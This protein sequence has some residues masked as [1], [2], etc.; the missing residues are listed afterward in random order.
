AYP[1]VGM[2]GP[3]Y[4][5]Y[6]GTIIKLDT[7]PKNF[8]ATF[9]VD[10]DDDPTAEFAMHFGGSMAAGVPLTVCIDDTY[11]ADPDYTAPPPEEEVALPG[12]RVNQVGYLPKLSKIATVVSDA[13]EPLDWELL[14]SAGKPVATGKTTV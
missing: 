4:A 7:V 2:S 1:K 6:F 3:P 10:K 13:T 8:A 11:L 9:T 14:S 12:V 5:E